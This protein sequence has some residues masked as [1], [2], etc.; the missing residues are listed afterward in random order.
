M[1][2]AKT[3]IMTCNRKLQPNAVFIGKPV[4]TSFHNI[5][6][7]LTPH[8]IPIKTGKVCSRRAGGAGAARRARVTPIPRL[9]RPKESETFSKEPL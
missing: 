1:Q 7:S 6:I 5:V 9:I 8:E 3:I 2:A 4:F